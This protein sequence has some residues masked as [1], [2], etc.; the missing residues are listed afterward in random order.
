[1]S[2]AARVA[3]VLAIVAA[4]VA[5]VWAALTLAGVGFIADAIATALPREPLAP[6]AQMRLDDLD[7]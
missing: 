3:Y 1:M 7:L 4:E 6:E 5:P 2:P